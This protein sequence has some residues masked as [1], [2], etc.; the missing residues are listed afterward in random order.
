[1]TPE[2]HSLENDDQTPAFLIIEKQVFPLNRPVTSIGRRLNNHLVVDDGRVSRLHAQ[3]R[4]IKGVY[5]LVDLNS[6]GGT[7][8]NGQKIDQTNLYSGDTISLAGFP[9]MFVQDS[10]QLEKETK[11]YT[12]P[13]IRSE[14]EDRITSP[15]DE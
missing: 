7:F 2:Q 13:T 6:T 5:Y 3:I 10:S 14:K 12:T 1:M 9:M 15:K 4:I 8:V 11:D